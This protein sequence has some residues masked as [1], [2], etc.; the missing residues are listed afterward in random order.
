MDLALL[1]LTA[2]LGSIVWGF[3]IDRL[4]VRP[5]VQG[6]AG[7]CALA[8]LAWAAALRGIERREAS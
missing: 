1:T 8:A 7:L 2:A 5:V 4:G 6:V 3:A